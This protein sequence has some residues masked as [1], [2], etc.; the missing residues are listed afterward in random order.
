M[1]RLQPGTR[2]APARQSG[3]P[4]QSRP[5]HRPEATHGGRPYTGFRVDAHGRRPSIPDRLRRPTESLCATEDARGE[6]VVP[7]R[8]LGLSLGKRRLSVSQICLRRLGTLPSR[9]GFGGLGHQFGV[10]G[11][12]P[13][14]EP[15]TRPAGCHGAG[16]QVTF[17]DTRR[18]ALA[19]GGAGRARGL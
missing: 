14:R 10:S 4:S 9:G 15:G 6:A 16:S 11:S 13:K 5:G 3:R 7:R 8:G 2:T 1:E 19:E 17:D 18:L 12:R